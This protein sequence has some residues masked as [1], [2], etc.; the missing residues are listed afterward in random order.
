L[1]FPW[2][3]DKTVPLTSARD[4][5]E[6]AVSAIIRG[7][8]SNS[9]LPRSGEVRHNAAPARW[10]LRRRYPDEYLALTNGDRAI[11]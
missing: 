8:S 3:Y 7:I 5:A 11:I 2:T 10:Q 4:R 1:V 6:V 9:K